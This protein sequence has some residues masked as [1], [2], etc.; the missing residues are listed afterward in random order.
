MRELQ[1]SDRNE[2]EIKDSRSGSGI[3]L[4]YRNPT[5]EEQASYQARMIKRKGNKVTLNLY[6]T[7]LEFG[8]KVITGFRDGDFGFGGKPISS[9]SSAENYREDWKEVVRA[10]AHDIVTTLGRVVFENTS[11]EEAI[12]IEE[13]DVLEEDAVPLGQS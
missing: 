13:A 9:D 12:E 10:G 2:I 6:P 3:L 5:P 4:Y 1:A 8:L 7:R 11:V